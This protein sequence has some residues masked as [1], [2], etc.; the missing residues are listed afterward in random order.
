MVVEKYIKVDD[1]VPA[2]KALSKDGSIHIPV[3]DAVEARY[4]VWLDAGKNMYGQNLTRCSVCH[5]NAIEGGLFCRCCGAR[6]KN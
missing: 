2:V 6:M 3:V 4:G 1:L 5:S